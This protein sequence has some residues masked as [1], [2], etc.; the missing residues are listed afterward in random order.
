MPKEERDVKIFGLQMISMLESMQGDGCL[1]R[2][3]HHCHQK[4]QC[5]MQH[6]ISTMGVGGMHTCHG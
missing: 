4:I 2:G 6:S 1:Q 5:G 3:Y